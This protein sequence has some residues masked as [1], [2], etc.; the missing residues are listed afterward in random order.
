MRMD[1]LDLLVASAMLVLISTPALA[2]PAAPAPV[3]GIGC[4]A[5]ALAAFGYRKLR[6]RIG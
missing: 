1:R 2:I 4:G 6:N 5:L 3:A